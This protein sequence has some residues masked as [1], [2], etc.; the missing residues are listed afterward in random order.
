MRTLNFK[1]TKYRC[2]SAEHYADKKY[3]SKPQ[4]PVSVLIKPIKVK[5]TT[6]SHVKSIKT[7]ESYSPL[8]LSKRVSVH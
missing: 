2:S 7:Q 8:L 1:V 6:Y 4:T 5:C 3:S